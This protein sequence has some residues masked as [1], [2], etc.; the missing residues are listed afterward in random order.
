MIYESF[1]NNLVGLHS[2]ASRTINPPSQLP[3]SWAYESHGTYS[4]KTV[5]SLSRNVPPVHAPQRVLFGI[6]SDP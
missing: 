3:R 6:S 2:K 1:V 4:L 5:P